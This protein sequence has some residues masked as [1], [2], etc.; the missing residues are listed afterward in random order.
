[1]EQVAEEISRLVAQDGYRV[2][3][4]SHRLIELERNNS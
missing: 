4:R 1:M 3:A 2:V